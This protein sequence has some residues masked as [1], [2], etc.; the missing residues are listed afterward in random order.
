MKPY[1]YKPGTKESGN[2]WTSLSDDLNSIALENLLFSTTQKSV[3]DRFKNIMNKYK[4]KIRQQEASSGGVDE[5]TELDNLIENIKGESDA[6]IQALGNAALE[7]EKKIFNKML[8]M[9]RTLE[10]W[11]WRY[12]Q[13][14][15]RE[16][17]LMI[18][19]RP[20]ETMVLKL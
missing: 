20:N 6:A 17:G 7:K 19:G 4:K 8:K 3:R 9:L 10:K 5:N 1:Q 12:F 2:C 14:Q 15:E 18:I 16:K 13:S 11:R